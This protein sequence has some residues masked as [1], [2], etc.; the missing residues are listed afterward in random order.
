MTDQVPSVP[1]LPSAPPPAPR[2]RWWTSLLLAIA[3]LIVISYVAVLLVNRVFLTRWAAQML[4]EGFLVQRVHLRWPRTVVFD[5]VRWAAPTTPATPWLQVPRVTADISVTSLFMRRLVVKDFVLNQPRITL[6]RDADGQWNLP[7]LRRSSAVPHG[8]ATTRHHWDVAIWSARMK[9]G[10]ILV[11]DRAVQEGF[12]AELNACQL[13]VRQPFLPLHGWRTQVAFSADAKL[14]SEPAAPIRLTGWVDWP[15]KDLEGTLTATSL[16]IGAFE[17]YLNR[18]RVTLRLYHALADVTVALAAVHGDFTADAQMNLNHLTEGDVSIKGVTVLNAKGVITDPQQTVSLRVML[19]GP[20]DQPGAWK[21][22]IAPTGQ[23]TIKFLRPLFAGRKETIILK[24]MPQVASEQMIEHVQETIKS[25]ADQLK[26]L[27]EAP[28]PTTPP[29]TA[30][31]EPAA[32]AASTAPA[33]VQP[34]GGEPS[35][36]QPKERATTTE[37]PTTP[38]P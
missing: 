3:L 4:P 34:N 37:A 22:T 27:F 16:D 19:R 8:V 6:Q 30:P 18:G 24:V 32:P 1:P 14:R 23:Q 11:D 15:H 7:S 5:H 38:S 21:R 26:S 17:P 12:H 20:L 10:T 2:G 36:A 28:A 25:A 13:D 9:E 29:P 31:T 35:A 33:S